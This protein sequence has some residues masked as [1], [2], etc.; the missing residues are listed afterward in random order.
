MWSHPSKYTKKVIWF[1]DFLNQFLLTRLLSCEFW[2][3]VAT[4]HETIDSSLEMIRFRDTVTRSYSTLNCN[5]CRFHKNL[6]DWM[7]WRACWKEH[8]LRCDLGKILTHVNL[9]DEKPGTADAHEFRTQTV[10]PCTIL[11][12]P[13]TRYTLPAFVR[14]K[15]RSLHYVSAYSRTAHRN[16]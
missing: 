4:R 1:R 5:N 10:F 16:N 9:W 8:V 15:F 6:S 12:H 3:R 13:N 7:N 2:L 14:L 11:G